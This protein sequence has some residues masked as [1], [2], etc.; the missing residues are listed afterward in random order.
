MNS[1]D[2]RRGEAN[3][4]L[5]LLGAC[6]GQ[7]E[8]AANPQRPFAGRSGINLGSLLDVLQ[9]L[10]NREMYGLR[11]DDFQ[12]NIV[13]HYTLMNSHAV[14]KWVA[15]DGRSTPRMPEVESRENIDRLANQIQAV[16]ARVVIGLGRPI[17]DAHLDRRGKDSAPMRAI[18]MLAPNH[19]GI[20]FLITGHPSPRAI[21]RFG[22]GNRRRWFESTLSKFPPE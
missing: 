16:G 13:D 9:V 21:N 12:S 18:R 11:P 14:P 7:D 10:A 6:P 20:T 5:V 22:R 17:N 1:I 19:Q 4:E 2:F 3:P 15:R 8:W